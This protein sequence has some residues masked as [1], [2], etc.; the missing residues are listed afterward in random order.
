LFIVLHDVIIFLI[1]LCHFAFVQLSCYKVL[2]YSIGVELSTHVLFS[3]EACIGELSS[4][5]R[6]IKNKVHFV[7]K[8]AKKLLNRNAKH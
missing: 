3:D 2:L 5:R 8:T 7:Q 1:T 6:Y 4:W